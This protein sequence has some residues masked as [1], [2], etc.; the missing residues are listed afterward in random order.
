MK[1]DPVCGT[2]F[3]VRGATAISRY[4]DRYYYFCSLRC[5]EAFERIPQRFTPA[6]GARTP[7]RIRRRWKA[8]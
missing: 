4:R 3:D 6:L 8:A 2:V 5:R 1:K 7:K